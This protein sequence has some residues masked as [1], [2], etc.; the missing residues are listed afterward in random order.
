M[1]VT[2][3]GEPIYL[4]PTSVVTFL[5]HPPAPALQPYDF[6]LLYAALERRMGEG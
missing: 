2:R 4:E 6:T 5:T 3:L 1:T